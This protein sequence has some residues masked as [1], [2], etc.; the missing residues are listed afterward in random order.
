MEMFI[1]WDLAIVLPI[2]HQPRLVTVVKVINVTRKSQLIRLEPK[3]CVVRDQ[4]FD[5]GSIELSRDRLG[6][7]G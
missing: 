4:L 5:H 7:C 3:S 2:T 6:I 1:F